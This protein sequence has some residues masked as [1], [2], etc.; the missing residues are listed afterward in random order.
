MP[1]EHRRTRRVVKNNG[2]QETCNPRK[3][4]ILGDCLDCNGTTLCI[5]TVWDG[6]EILRYEPQEG[7]DLLG[8]IVY[9][10]K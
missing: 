5:G 9:V 4:L 6:R 10:K 2:I 3:Q 1:C 7:G 8:G